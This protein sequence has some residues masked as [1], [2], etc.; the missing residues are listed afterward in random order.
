MEAHSSEWVIGVAGHIDHGKTSLVK[1]LTGTDTDRLP[2]EKSRGI[3]IELGFAALTLPN[4]THASVVDMPGHEK[5]IRAMISGAGGIDVCLLVVAANEGVMPQTREHLA[6]AQLL[7]VRQAVVALSKCDLAGDDVL[8][9]AMEEVR[10]VLAST[11][12]AHAPI[13]AVSANTGKGLPELLQALQDLKIKRR[14]GEGPVVVP[15][16][17]VFVRKGFGVVITGTLI[18]GTIREGAALCCGP[19]GLDHSIR[20]VRVRGLQVHGQSVSEARAGTRVAVNLAGIEVNDVSRGAWLFSPNEV[21]VTTAFDAEMTVLPGTRKILGRRSHFDLAIGAAH[22]DCTAALLEGEEL[23]PGQSA[24]VR[25]T[26]E[27][28]VLLR[29]NERFV[30]RGP[31]SMVQ[32]GSTV[33]GGRVVRP[34]AE[35]VKKRDLA[36]TRAKDIFAE[37]NALETRLRIELEAAGPKGLSAKDLSVRVG[38]A[39]TAEMAAQS[40]LFVVSAQRYVCDAVVHTSSQRIL[41]LLSAWH[42]S[43]PA[44]RGVERRAMTQLGDDALIDA[45]LQHLLSEKRIARDGELYC[46]AGWKPKDPDAVA[47]LAAVLAMLTTGGI[48][49]PRVDEMA[50]SL[51]VEPKALEPALKRLIERGA[52]VKLNTEYYAEAIAM[53]E[54]EKKLL[55]WLKAEQT[56]DAQ[57]YKTLTGASRKWA[58]PLAE[59]FDGKKLTIRVGDVRKLRGG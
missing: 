30:L 11:S 38:A 52:I 13:V 44:S 14:S 9:L 15:I 4:G 45:I 50:Q 33:G 19:F 10:E 21:A 6:V 24:L 47:H 36:L 17:R 18:S 41:Q 22:T 49:P 35:R 43:Q 54:L 46:R 59:Y 48:T 29:P 16:D 40:K 42:T 34:I 51:K 8:D 2:E 7:G 57:G 28:P 32:Y 27:E 5:F 3:T 26:T 58:I 56:I 20:E 31:P 37:P 23:L 12:Y 55:A 39:I 25:I 1:A 53:D